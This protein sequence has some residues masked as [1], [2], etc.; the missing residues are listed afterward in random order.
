M[1]HIRREHQRNIMFLHVM[2]GVCVWS[3]GLDSGVRFHR[4]LAFS[5]HY[6]GEI[7]FMP[8]FYIRN[9]VR[10]LRILNL[11]KYLY[12]FERKH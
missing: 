9:Q 10:L 2:F 8:S 6:T 11:M 7:S 12:F 4:A 1:C 3:D 5:P